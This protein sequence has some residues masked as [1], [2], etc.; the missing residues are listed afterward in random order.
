[1]RTVTALGNV[2]ADRGA[3]AQHL[4]GDDRFLVLAQVLVEAHDAQREGFGL[5][6]E[7]AVFHF[8]EPFVA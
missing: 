1:M 3:R 7:D 5:G 2:R 8:G 6:E 4:L